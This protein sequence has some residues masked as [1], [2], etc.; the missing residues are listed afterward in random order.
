[1]VFDRESE[2]VNPLIARIIDF[3]ETVK[4]FTRP[5]TKFEGYSWDRPSEL[6][7][8]YFLGKYFLDEKNRHIVNAKVKN[9]LNKALNK[10]GFKELSP[11]FELIKVLSYFWRGLKSFA[12][13]PF[14]VK[15]LFYPLAIIGAVLFLALWWFLEELPIKRAKDEF[16]EPAYAY[17][18][19]ECRNELL[20]MNGERVTVAQC[21]AIIDAIKGIAPETAT[22]QWGDFFAGIFLGPLYTLLDNLAEKYDETPDFEAT[23]NYV[24][25]V[26]YANRVNPWVFYPWLISQRENKTVAYPKYVTLLPPILHNVYL[27]I[28]SILAKVWASAESDEMSEIFDAWGM[29]EFAKKVEGLEHNSPIFSFISRALA[30]SPFIQLVTV[31]PTEAE[32]LYFKNMDFQAER[33]TEVEIKWLES[34]VGIFEVVGTHVDDSEITAGDEEETADDETTHDIPEIGDI[35]IGDERLDEEEEEEDYTD[36]G[37]TEEGEEEIE[38]THDI[39]IPDVVVDKDRYI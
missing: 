20:N 31:T 11:D 4:S 27:L 38:E 32:D 8:T 6:I 2:D 22:E 7:F 23:V 33:L 1:M 13:T 10:L 29:S 5:K 37:V 3:I 36:S 35:P 28:K 34:Y 16:G 17:E 30:T 18:E 39:E 14:G 24:S 25:G 19:I 21:E 15:I 12:M 26:F 9:G